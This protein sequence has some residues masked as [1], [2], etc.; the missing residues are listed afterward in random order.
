M[1][2]RRHYY[3]VHRYVEISIHDNLI[4]RLQRNQNEIVVY[5]LDNI[6]QINEKFIYFQT[7]A[8]LIIGPATGTPN[9]FSSTRAEIIFHQKLRR[10]CLFILSKE[11]IRDVNRIY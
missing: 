7:V 4:R 3:L 2:E 11:C 10:I 9:Y 6:L 1:P 8:A 5:H